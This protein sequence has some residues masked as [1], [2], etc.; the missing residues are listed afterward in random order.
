MLPDTLCLVLVQHLPNS[1]PV[2]LCHCKLNPRVEQ[3][4]GAV[5]TPGLLPFGADAEG[6]YMSCS[7]WHVSITGK[8][9]SSSTG[10]NTW[11]L[12]KVV[13]FSPCIPYDVHPAAS[14]TCSNHYF[15]DNFNKC[16]RQQ[17]HKFFKVTRVHAVHAEIL[18]FTLRMQSRE[19]EEL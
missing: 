2:K 11:K 15:P 4:H 18:W 14:A 9:R 5:W 6:Q 13:S 19:R 8:K 17:C 3:K 12:A 1:V 10:V 16:D 7:K